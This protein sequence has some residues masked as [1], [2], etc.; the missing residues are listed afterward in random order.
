MNTLF[1]GV[2]RW[3]LVGMGRAVQATI[4]PSSLF[5]SA[6][7]GALSFGGSFHFRFGWHIGR[8]LVLMKIP[9]AGLKPALGD[10]LPPLFYSLA[11]CV[12]VS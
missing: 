4:L 3:G 1:P 2:F 12:L 5:D 10:I 11:E 6:V 7:M 8:S 9:R